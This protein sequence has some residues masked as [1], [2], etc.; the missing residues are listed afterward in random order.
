MESVTNADLTNLNQLNIGEDA[1]IILN[2]T[3]AMAVISNYGNTLPF[4]YIFHFDM[5]M[6]ER[7]IGFIERINKNNV[8]LIDSYF[9]SD[10]S[11]T[12]VAIFN[13]F[14]ASHVAQTKYIH[15]QVINM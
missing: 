13:S 3:V 2:T 11:N 4:F 12:N 10:N 14:I 1:I 9:F 8:Y 15:A 6:L 5:K 7:D